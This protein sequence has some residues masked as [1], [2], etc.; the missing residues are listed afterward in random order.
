M[1]NILQKIRIEEIRPPNLDLGKLEG[2][3]NRL[4]ENPLVLR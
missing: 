1:S 3:L 4:N 2:I